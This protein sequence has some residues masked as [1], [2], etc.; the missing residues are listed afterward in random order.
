MSNFLNLHDTAKLYD[1]VMSLWIKYLDIFNLDIHSIK[2]EDLTSNFK[3]T[4]KDLLN[5][6]KL[7]WSDDLLEFYK[8]A[9]NKRIINTP[10][11]NQVNMPLYKNSVNRWMNYKNQFN[12]TKPI[13]EKWAK[14]FNY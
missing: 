1:K 5:F 12:E 2:Y 11:Y 3:K 14:K 4:T 6:L 10:S 9:E 13:L 7:D 8:T